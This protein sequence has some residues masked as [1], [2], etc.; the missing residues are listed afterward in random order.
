MSGAPKTGCSGEEML[1]RGRQDSH[2][3]SLTW[4]IGGGILKFSAGK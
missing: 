3:I 2:R 1:Q 4:P